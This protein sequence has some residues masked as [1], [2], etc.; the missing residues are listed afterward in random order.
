[1]LSLSREAMQAM[2][3]V[4]KGPATVA[5]RPQVLE[6]DVEACRSHQ[7]TFSTDSSHTL[8][9][10]TRN[11]QGKQILHGSTCAELPGQDT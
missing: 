10:C 2:P 5:P 11:I 3:E 4:P 6:A 7:I 8:T 9:H 1:M